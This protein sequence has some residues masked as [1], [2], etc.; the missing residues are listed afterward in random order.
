MKAAEKAGQ[1]ARSASPEEPGVSAAAMD[2]PGP[3][4]SASQFSR[5]DLPVFL[6]KKLDGND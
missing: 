2:D 6:L 3:I 1:I 4:V 5:S